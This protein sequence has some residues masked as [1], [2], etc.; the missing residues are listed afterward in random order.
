MSKRVEDILQDA[1]KTR[2]H[3]GIKWALYEKFKGQVN[4]NTRNTDE[5]DRALRQLREIFDIR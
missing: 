3:A 1:R 2:F 5:R 4:R